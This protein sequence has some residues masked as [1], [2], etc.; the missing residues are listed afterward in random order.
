MSAPDG[1]VPEVE[2]ELTIRSRVIARRSIGSPILFTI[3]YS[4][5]ASAIYFSLGVIAAIYPASR[6][7][8]S[9]GL[10]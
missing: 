6:K 5:L 2:S 4:S 7:P 8:G 9:A 3:V 10:S 1:A